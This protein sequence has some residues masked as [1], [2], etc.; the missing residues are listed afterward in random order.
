MICIKLTDLQTTELDLRLFF[1]K[2]GHVREAK[3]IRSSEGTSKGYGFIT[4]D[5]ED[6]AKTV[7]QISAVRHFGINRNICSTKIDFQSNLRIL[8]EYSCTI[9]IGRTKKRKN[10]N[11]KG[12]D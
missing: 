6:E 5:T 2:F 10:L 12:V 8:N 3:V 7:M 4:F 11:S 9:N 1:E